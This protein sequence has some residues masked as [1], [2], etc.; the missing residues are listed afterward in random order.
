M[1]QCLNSTRTSLVSLLLE[2]RPGAGKTALA[3]SLALMRDIPY[4]KLIS[5]DDLV[6][7]GE[8]QKCAKIQK[9]FDDAYKSKI[10][11]VVVDDIERLLEFVPIGPRFSNLV[12]QTLLVLLKKSPPPGHRLMVIATT[13]VLSVMAQMELVDVFSGTLHVPVIQSPDELK[14]ILIELDKA[15][16]TR[17]LEEI[18][19]NYTQPLP[20]KKLINLLEMTKQAH[21]ISGGPL[22]ALFMQNIVDAG[23]AQAN[24]D[25]AN[26]LKF[27]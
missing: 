1:S 21:A 19:R 12:L 15:F 5:P 13:S 14:K 7:F 26:E 18:A 8:N 3:A 24:K 22:S 27:Q 20:V 16:S 4:V 6:G 9:V 2:G 23:V 17:D 11:C 25:L 10:S